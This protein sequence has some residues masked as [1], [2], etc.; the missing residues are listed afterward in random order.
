MIVIICNIFEKN[1]VD[2]I[3]GDILNYIP[4]ELIPRL[5]EMNKNINNTYHILLAFVGILK[6]FES[7]NTDR[8]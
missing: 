8:I 5:A 1:G 2:V 4:A 7:I 6:R 3:S